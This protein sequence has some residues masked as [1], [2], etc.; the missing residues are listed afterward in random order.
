MQ[1][2]FGAILGLAPSAKSQRSTLRSHSVASD[3]D[4][5]PAVL[6]SIL[7]AGD[8]CPSGLWALDAGWMCSCLCGWRWSIGLQTLLRVRTFKG[9]MF[10]V[11][12]SLPCRG[13]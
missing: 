4:V 10:D 5:D 6:N 2:D 8:C 9:Q 7:Y 13:R 1:A 12:C 3:E 11:S